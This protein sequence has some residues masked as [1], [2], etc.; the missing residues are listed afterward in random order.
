MKKHRGRGNKN[1][2]VTGFVK[3]N[4]DGFG[5]LIPDDKEL[6][7]VYLPRKTMLGIM[8]GD[9]VE[10]E[11]FREND[12]RFSGEVKQ[13]LSRA[14]TQI[15]GKFHKTGFEGSGVIIDDSK[16]WGHDLKIRSELTKNAQEGQ[17]VVV[18]ISDYPDSSE[19][20]NGEVVEILGTHGDPLLDT[21]QVLYNHHIP[22]EFS[23]MNLKQVDQIPNEVSESDWQGRK[24][25]RSKKFVTIDGATAR[26]FD[27]AVYA[28]KDG[29]GFRVWVAIADVSHYVKEGTP[30]DRDAYER[31]TSV[32]FPDMVVPMLPEKL[33]NGLCS[34]NPHI[35]RLALVAEMKLDFSGNV[36][37]SDF[38]E[39]VFMSHHRLIYGEVEDMVNGFDNPKYL[40]VLPE[41]RLM[42]D[43]ARIL[44][45]KRFHE[46]SLDLDIPESQILIDATGVPTDV[47]RGD[48]LFAHRLIEELML[49]ANVAVAKFIAKS[50]KPSLY[51]IHEEPFADALK[52]LEVMAHNWGLRVR[53][54]TGMTQKNLMKMLEFVRDKPEEHILSIL[55]LRS[56]KQAQYSEENAGHFG[57]AFDCYTHFTSPIRRYPDLIVHRVLKKIINKTHS[58]LGADEEL[59]R[60]ATAGN[61][62][63]ACE[64]RSVKA[65]RE[66]KGIKKCRFMQRYVGETFDGMITGIAKFGIFVQLRTYDIDGL[67]KLDTLQGDRF[68]YDEEKQKLIGRKTG[69]VISLGDPVKIK[70]LRAD[71]EAQEIDFEWIDQKY[72]DTNNR[73]TNRTNDQERGETSPNSGSVRETRFSQY[74]GKSEAGPIHSKKN[75]KKRGT[76]KPKRR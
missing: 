39:A 43:I 57:L 33:S 8:S 4:A 23:P 74:R 20:F 38:Y 24:D 34:L 36:V 18:K 15:V 32:Y 12:G 35:P 46:G 52:N 60:M 27:D 71:P 42:A 65:E 2:T 19:G 30:L 13:I 75:R 26:D 6:V 55:I 76:G 53:F 14:M 70:V 31:G 28:E 69:T 40:D 7:D 68:Q 61:I 22:V 17:L 41:L 51:R 49:M 47:V 3:R 54:G 59:D 11:S 63:S 72:A 16:A 48:R 9:R 5:F 73:P 50:G 37:D 45:K 66:L 67:V 58:G 21:K 62:L 44:M 25:L 10:A 64:Q 56:M 29:S 1:S